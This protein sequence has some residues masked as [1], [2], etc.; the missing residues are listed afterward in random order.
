MLY[1]QQLSTLHKTL[2]LFNILNLFCVVYMFQ[3]FKDCVQKGKYLPEHLQEYSGI[4]FA[5]SLNKLNPKLQIDKVDITL[6]NLPQESKSLIIV[7]TIY[8]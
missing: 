1:V 8:L 7:G 2:R 3:K 4:I 6:R 5:F